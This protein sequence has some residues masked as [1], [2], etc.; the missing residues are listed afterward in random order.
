M[1]TSVI[2]LII[3][4]AS[5]GYAT[6]VENKEG[7]EVA[8]ELIY[9]SKWFEVLLILLIINLLGSSVKY[10]ILNKKSGLLGLTG[11]SDLR[12]IQIGAENGNPDC[13]LAL[14]MTAYR[15]K[16]QIGAYAAAMDGLDA[17]VFTAGIGENSS[18][19]RAKICEDLTDGRFA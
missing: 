13:I 10:E 7:T 5:I 14:E 11:F 15:I 12:E 17:I 19:L 2:L 9:N 6:F 1:A 8:R 3:F 18:I 4:A 16:K